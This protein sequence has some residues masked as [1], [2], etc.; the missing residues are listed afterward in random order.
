M[1][2]EQINKDLCLNHMPLYCR[3]LNITLLKVDS[4]FPNINGSR[5]PIYFN[6]L[7]KFDIVLRAAISCRN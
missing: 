6:L 4:A 2:L 1:P 5:T 7:D 3:G